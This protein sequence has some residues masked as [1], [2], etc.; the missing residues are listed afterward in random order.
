MQFEVDTV[1]T[2][3]PFSLTTHHRGRVV[4]TAAHPLRPGWFATIV[5]HEGE[6]VALAE[7]GTKRRAA[8][9]HFLAIIELERPSRLG[10]AMVQMDDPD[11]R[12]ARP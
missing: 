5:E 4:T 7:S 10:W 2:G 8:E 1:L 6:P 3:K 11:A 9:T 12:D